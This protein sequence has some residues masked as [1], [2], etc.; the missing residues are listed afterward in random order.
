MWSCLLSPNLSSTRILESI[1]TF[2][3]VDQLSQFR[4]F[5]WSFI[6]VTALSATSQIWVDNPICGFARNIDMLRGNL[7]ILG[8]KG[9]V[10]YCTVLYRMHFGV[11]RRVNG[12]SNSCSHQAPVGEKVQTLSIPVLALIRGELW[13]AVVSR[14]FG[15]WSRL[16][17]CIS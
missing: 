3:Q 12:I 10:Q 4:M 11:S 14:C 1:F 7:R 8:T 9:D 16:D 5:G 13:F 17:W 6:F 2:L 15:S